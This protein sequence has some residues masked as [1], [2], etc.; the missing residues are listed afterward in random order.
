MIIK[1]KLESINKIKEL[2]LNRFPEKLFR[3]G[4]ETEVLKFLKEY[5]TK[6]YALRDK[7]KAR[8]IFKLKVP[9]NDILE[10]IK[11]YDLFTINVSSYNYIHNQILVGEICD[12]NKYSNQSLV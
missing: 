4:E 2:N 5:P 10:E 12:R 7:P 1:N 11:D 3:K 6:Y 8:G 9:Y